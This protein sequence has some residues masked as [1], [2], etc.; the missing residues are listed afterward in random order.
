MKT[1]A[2]QKL[3]LT[4]T[5]CLLALMITSC[6]QN[7]P[8]FRGPEY[9]MVA[10]AKNL[11]DTWGPSENIR[12]STPVDGESWTSPVVWGNKV[13]FT[14]A[15]P[16][17]VAPEPER[18]APPP[19]RPPAEAAGNAGNAQNPPP[20]P[21]SRPDPSEDL[22]YL[23]TVY[24]WEVC[25]LDLE[26]GAVMWRTIAKEGSP[27][28]N[29]HRATNYASE[30]PVTDGQ[31]LYVYF[32][33][34]GLYCY[35]LEGKLLWEKDLGSYFTLNGWGTGSSPVLYQDRLFVQVDNE[36]NSFLVALDA[37]TGDEL[38]RKDR[39]ESTNYSTPMIWKNSL[40]T[41][42]VTGGQTA[43]SYDPR[44]G[45]LLWELELAGYYNI[46]SPV[47]TQDLL[48]LGNTAFRD[49]PGTMFCVQ[50]GA[51]GDIT[52]AEGETTS[53]GVLWSNP[54]AP[55]SNPSPLLYEGLLYLVSNRGGEIT[56]LDAANGD[57]VYQEKIDN[58]A[59][60]W[61]SPWAHEDK[62]FFTDEKGV[63]QV[64]KAGRDFEVLHQNVLEDKVWASVAVTKD[65]YL[66]KGTGQIYC[67]AD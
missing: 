27:G 52:P 7:W 42:L 5:C 39:E 4:G 59:A 10:R 14:A 45:E 63:T 20:P 25:C 41:E 40:R 57:L 61:A 44:T 47:A 15:I 13:F 38:W 21:Q 18:Q 65:A 17:K 12:W 8:Q 37:E 28:G 49:K 32:G 11:P 36:E 50:A 66:L 55:T 3:M 48:Y 43:R 24:R 46:P 56:C 54:D 62:I 35:D 67:I 60:C 26:T 64:L 16:V 30:T 9:N 33:N 53:S 1:K 2:R 51:E 58:V 6:S 31:R 22:S 23:Q 34:N 19:P 29:K